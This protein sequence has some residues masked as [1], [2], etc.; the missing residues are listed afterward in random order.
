MF[1]IVG[2]SHVSVAMMTSGFVLSA[3][4][5]IWCSCFWLTGSWHSRFSGAWKALF[6]LFFPFAFVLTSGQGLVCF[7]HHLYSLVHPVGWSCYLS[8]W[9]L[10]HSIMT[11]SLDCHISCSPIWWLL[12]HLIQGNWMFYCVHLGSLCGTTNHKYHIL[13]LCYPMLQ[14]GHKFHMDRW[15]C[16]CELVL[17]WG[18]CR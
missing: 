4:F 6:L 17:G 11:D 14:A 18:W 16:R 3:R 12:F 15:C 1:V 13:L 10:I 9:L 2:S 7:V 8:E 5:C